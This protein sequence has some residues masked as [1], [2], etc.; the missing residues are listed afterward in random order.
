MPN[1][2][3]KR[4]LVTGGSSGIGQSIAIELAKAGAVV[5]FTYHTNFQGARLTQQYIENQGCKA[6]PFEMSLEDTN[7]IIPIFKNILGELGGID[8]LVN[9]AGTLTRH[10]N[11][12]NIPL[13]ELEKVF[14]INVHAS[15]LLIQEAAHRMIE[16][17][18]GGSIINISSIS[19]N[20]T[21]PGL[22]HYECS[23]AALN[24]LTRGAAKDL[25]KYDIRVNAIAPGL[26]ST[27]INLEQ[28]EKKPELWNSRCSQIPLGRAGF[29]KDIS[30]LAVFLVS[31]EAKWITGSI[32]TVD[33]GLS[34]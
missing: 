22:T 25:A 21:S 24:C 27:N 31:D 13:D 26:V 34:I 10:N 11:F 1:I 19:A 33:G 23:K 28:R 12:I 29:P 20:M 8:I 3:K 18:I 17:D 9:N 32:F 7:S 6:Y 30:K 14:K 16:Q 2:L 15:F 5:A 4:C